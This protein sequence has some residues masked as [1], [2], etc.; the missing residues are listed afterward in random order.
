MAAADERRRFAHKPAAAAYDDGTHA[1][2]N[3]R[4]PGWLRYGLG[5]PMNADNNYLLL[6]PRLI[7]LPSINFIHNITTIYIWIQIQNDVLWFWGFGVLG[8]LGA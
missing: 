2:A 6:N 7:L 3:G 5:W 1:G 8:A 4:Q